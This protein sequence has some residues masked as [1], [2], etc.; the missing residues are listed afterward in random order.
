MGL[1]SSSYHSHSHDN[2][3][4]IKSPDTVKVHEHKAP[5][6]ESI[7]LMEEAHNKAIENIIAKVKVED[8][9]G[10]EIYIIGSGEMHKEH[11]EHIVK[12]H[13]FYLHDI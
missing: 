13:N 12:L 11:A 6:D 3:T 5:T 1:L 9:D 10:N 2:S 8:K 7:K 4:H